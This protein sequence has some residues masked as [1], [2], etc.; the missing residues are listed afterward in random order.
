MTSGPSV[1]G[2]SPSGIHTVHTFSVTR[3]KKGASKWGPVAR[4]TGAA[5]RIR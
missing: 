2:T 5:R 4:P 1:A 3:E